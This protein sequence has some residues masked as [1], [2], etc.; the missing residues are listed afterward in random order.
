MRVRTHACAGVEMNSRV[1]GPIDPKILSTLPGRG[2]GAGA[3]HVVVLSCAR[4][5]VTFHIFF[6]LGQGTFNQPTKS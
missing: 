3:A 6:F 4:S 1:N 2:P 5:A